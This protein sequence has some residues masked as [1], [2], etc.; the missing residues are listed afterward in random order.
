MTRPVSRRPEVVDETVGPSLTTPRSRKV[1]R[2]R[3]S[4]TR[5]VETCRPE[6]VL[7]TGTGTDRVKGP[8]Q[9]T[10]LVVTFD[11]SGQSGRDERR[12]GTSFETLLH[13][14]EENRGKPYIEDRGWVRPRSERW[15]CVWGRG[16]LLP[17]SLPSL[18]R[19]ADDGPDHYLAGFQTTRPTYR[20]E[21]FPRTL[22]PL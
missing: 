19:S 13:T 1:R 16:P 8:L 5:R 7:E 18:S 10:V 20:R 4:F 11:A 12:V 2:R 17:R 14:S 21:D 9:R 3:D 22:F 6:W 15:G